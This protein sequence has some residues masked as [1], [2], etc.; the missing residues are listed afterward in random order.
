MDKENEKSKNQQAKGNE[1]SLPGSDNFMEMTDFAQVRSGTGSEVNEGSDS[2]SSKAVV[3]A[4]R[5]R[6]T[7]ASDTHIMCAILSR[8]RSKHLVKC[9][10]VCTQWKSLIETNSYLISLQYR[11]QKR[12]RALLFVST[13]PERKPGEPE[14]VGATTISFTMTGPTE[15]QKLELDRSTF[16]IP[17]QTVA[18]LVCIT[19]GTEEFLI[20]NPCTGERSPWIETPNVH[21]IVGGEKRREVDCIAFGYNPTTKE[22]KVLCISSVKRKGIARGLSIY[23]PS[24]PGCTEKDRQFFYGKFEDGKGISR[25]DDVEEVE[26]DEE[27]VC[28]VFT[29]GEN[30]WRRI[31]AVP[32]YS[33]A[34]KACYVGEIGLYNQESKSVYVRGKIYWR[35]RYTRRG[36][37]LMVFDV[38]TEKF[39]VISIP[40]YVTE[41]P[42]KYPQ[43]VELLEVDGNIAV[44]NY[45][46]G[47]PVSFW[48][49][50]QDS[51]D[52]IYQN[53]KTPCDWNGTLDLS[54]EAVRCTPIIV[55]KRQM[56]ET[57]YFFNWCEENFTAST[58]NQLPNL[59]YQPASHLCVPSAAACFEGVMRFYLEVSL[60]FDNCIWPFLSRRTMNFVSVFVMFLLVASFKFTESC[61]L[62]LSFSMRTLISFP[63]TG[64]CEIFIRMHISDIVQDPSLNCFN[65][66]RFLRLLVIILRCTKMHT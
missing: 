6:K 61:C 17:K 23:C 64:L 63:S 43:T 13:A 66:D 19:S 58:G 47:C 12:K 15:V 9:K 31:D 65:R 8:L 40:G 32:P 21:E 7:P 37:V 10:A 35:F 52:W 53:V 22:H 50:D 5:S 25:S 26:A 18:G 46:P 42:W 49:L 57:I 28:E 39:S 11:Q 34:S 3:C 27:Q 4:S 60:N 59:N 62:Y 24:R 48:V 54:I 16:G 41:T 45:T 20:Y 29:V 36:E 30:T 33:L 44:L 55:L 14:R 1:N 38:R 2:S 56:S 51:N